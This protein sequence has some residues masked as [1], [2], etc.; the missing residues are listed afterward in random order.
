MCV[1][2]S[3]APERS[4]KVT[5][6]LKTVN[7]VFFLLAVRDV[8]MRVEGLIDRSVIG[9]WELHR[10]EPQAVPGPFSPSRGAFP[11]GALNK[12]AWETA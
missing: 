10:E 11:K 9:G 5:L 7:S 8:Q 4:C 2:T 12:I 1:S 6:A 3:T